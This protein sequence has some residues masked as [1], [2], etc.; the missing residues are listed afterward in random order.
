[1]VKKLDYSVKERVKQGHAL[2]VMEAFY[3]IQGEGAYTGQAAYFIRL[4]GCDVGCVWCDVKESWE[5]D[6]HPV[7]EIEE[8]IQNAKKHPGRLAIITGGEPLMHNLE[9]LTKR[10]KE[11]GFHINIETSGTHKFTG[12]LDYITL[13]PKKFKK[14][15][16]EA[17]QLAS[18]FKVVVFHKSDIQWAINLSEKLNKDCKLYIQPE[19]SK[20]QEITPLLVEF[21]KNN[22][23]WQL[24]LQTHKYIDIP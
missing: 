6:A 14:P 5:Q 17:Y 20:R 1:M 7:L 2:P 4:A 3:T 22:P 24:S 21:V 19:W 11:E 8:I 13:S 12:H 10:L 9:P 18:E 23:E 15:V 16:E